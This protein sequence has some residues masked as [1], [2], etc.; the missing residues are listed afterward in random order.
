MLELMDKNGLFFDVIEVTYVI[1]F[2]IH[3]NISSH[4]LFSHMHDDISDHQFADYFKCV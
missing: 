2:E 3:W 4:F 1:N